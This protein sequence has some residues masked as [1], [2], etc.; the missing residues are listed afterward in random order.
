MFYKPSPLYSYLM[1]IMISI[2]QMR[3]VSIREGMVFVPHNTAIKW[4]RWVSRVSVFGSKANPL[5]HGVT[6]VRMKL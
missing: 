5:N 1:E 3:K 6:C 2:L 4:Q